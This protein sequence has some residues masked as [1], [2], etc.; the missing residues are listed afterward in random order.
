MLQDPAAT[1]GA[2]AAAG[3]VGMDGALVTAA[4][5]ALGAPAEVADDAPDPLVSALRRRPPGVKVRLP[6]CSRCGK[7][8]LNADS[9]RGA[10]RGVSGSR[11]C[12]AV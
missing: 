11:W 2:V 10:Q 5:G 9:L 1:A 6:Q 12:L 8:N 3:V 7:V 4:V